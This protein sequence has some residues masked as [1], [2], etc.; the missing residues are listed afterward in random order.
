MFDFAELDLKTRVNSSCYQRISFA[1]PPRE[2]Y[3]FYPVR[4]IV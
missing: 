1:N 3:P 2:F 4:S